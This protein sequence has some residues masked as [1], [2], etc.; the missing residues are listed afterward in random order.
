MSAHRSWAA[1]RYKRPL[2]TSQRVQ[3][4]LQVQRP[5]QVSRNE[6][7]NSRPTDSV[8]MADD[9]QEPT[10]VPSAKQKPRALHDDASWSQAGGRSLMAEVP[11]IML[12]YS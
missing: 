12:A 6:S 3:A 2:D 1:Q 7:R 5:V 4:H 9:I 10:C 8:R 11:G